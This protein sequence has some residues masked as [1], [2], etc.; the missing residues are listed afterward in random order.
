MVVNFRTR[1][2]SRDTRKLAKTPLLILK[3]KTLRFV[4]EFIKTHAL[5]LL[6]YM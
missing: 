3:K 2:I 4:H 5:L 6:F 1:R